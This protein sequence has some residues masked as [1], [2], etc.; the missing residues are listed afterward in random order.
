MALY[1]EGV[2]LLQDYSD[3]VGFVGIEQ[4]SLVDTEQMTLDLPD[5][6]EAEFHIPTA[7][8]TGIAGPFF[9][10]S[11]YVSRGVPVVEHSM[12]DDQ[13]ELSC[14]RLTINNVETQTDAEPMPQNT[15]HSN[16][17]FTQDRIDNLEAKI[18]EL[19]DWKAQQMKRGTELKRMMD[20]ILEL[21]QEQER[22]LNMD[23]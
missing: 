8:D 13:M 23:K 1:G 20:E 4:I 19:L 9:P 14:P 12:A 17:S 10:S 15:N 21:L 3:N 6:E 7:L 22:R 16:D 5:H 11:D 2:D 18:I